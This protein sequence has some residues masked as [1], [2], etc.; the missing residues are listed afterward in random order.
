MNQP[1]PYQPDLYIQERRD[2][3]S[4][5]Q[6]IARITADYQAMAGLAL[7]QRQAQQLFNI[8]DTE[9][10]RRVLRELVGRGVIK[11]DVDGLIIRGEA[12]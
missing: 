4:R 9:R 8:D 7:T 10:F 5:E 12:Q 6:L 2:A 3:S 11:I 1:E